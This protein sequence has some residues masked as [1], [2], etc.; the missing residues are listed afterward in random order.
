MFPREGDM[1]NQHIIFCCS[2]VT[3]FYRMFE[4]LYSV[5]FSWDAG[6]KYCLTKRSLKVIKSPPSRLVDYLMNPEAVPE[7]LVIIHV[8]A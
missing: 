2:G 8:V 1:V 5:C 3:A 7:R 6:Q 4:D